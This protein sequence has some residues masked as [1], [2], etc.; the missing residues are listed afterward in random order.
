MI[1]S[2]ALVR[3]P[4]FLGV[5]L[6]E[7]DRAGDQGVL[8]P[9]GHGGVAPGEV[10]AAVLRF[11]RL[12]RLGELGEP[13]GGVGPA[14]QEDV[15][16]PFEQVL[17]DLFV[18]LELAGV[19]DPHVQAGAD[20]VIEERGVHR[21]ADRVV[22]AVRERHVAHAAGG[23]AVGQDP[24]ELAHRLD[25]LD[26]VVVVLLDAGADRQ[27]VDVEDDVFGREAGLL[28]E[29]L[30]GALADGDLVVLGDGLPLFVERH[31]DHRGAVAADQPG[32]AEELFLAPLQADRV[33]DRLALHALEPRLDDAPLGAVDHDRDLGDARVGRDQ[34]Q[35][36]GHRLLA[37]DQ[38]LVHVDVEDVGAPLDL[39]A[40]HGQRGLEVAALDQAGKPL[41][42]GDVGPLAD[43]DEV[44]LGADRPAAPCRCSWTSGA[45]REPAA[46]A[47]PRRPRRSP[48]SIPGVVPQQ[49]PTMLSQ[50]LRANSP[51]T[52]AVWSLSPRKPPKPSGM[53]A[54][55]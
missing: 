27:D 6:D 10:L 44:G 36:P 11:R 48:R 53:P 17:G 37:V 50:P 32:L 34:V 1:D 46:A 13:V 52:A 28:G 35:E 29:Q 18:D 4:G 25:E 51:R 3:L 39:V 8:E 33:D 7:V 45:A 9:L 40:R 26:R 23:L 47:R 41:R 21:L 24:L 20:G 12:D 14:V 15:L 2:G 30:V 38:A 19:D 55:G 42:A 43:H 54:L 31:H 22:A 5:G 49:P 16:D